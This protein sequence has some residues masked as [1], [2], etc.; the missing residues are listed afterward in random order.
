[1]KKNVELNKFWSEFYGVVNLSDYSCDQNELS[2]LGKG[3]KLELWTLHPD[4]INS[5]S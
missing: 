1:M 5:V 3:L 4:I 2:V